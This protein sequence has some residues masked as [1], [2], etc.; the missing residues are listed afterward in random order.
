MYAAIAIFS[1]SIA[2]A[3]WL[4]AILGCLAGDLVSFQTTS[5]LKEPLS[6]YLLTSLRFLLTMQSQ[7]LVV[8]PAAHSAIYIGVWSYSALL[9]GYTKVSGKHHHAFRA[10]DNLP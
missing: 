5:R 10:D 3:Q 6:S 8:G 1:P 2:F 9:T 7:A 4:G